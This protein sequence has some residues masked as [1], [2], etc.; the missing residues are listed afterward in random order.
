MKILVADDDRVSQRLLQVLLKKW[1]HETLLA[2]DGIETLKIMESSD[3]P[4]IVL[5][6][7][8]MPGMD[9]IEVCRRIRSQNTASPPYIIFI[10]AKDGSVDMVRG[11]ESG[12]SDFIRKPFKKEELKARIGV[13]IRTVNL[14]EELVK[15]HRMMEQIAMYD[16][17][18]ETF[19]RRAMMD[20]IPREISRVKRENRLLSL[21]LLDIDH[22][23]KINDT[24]GHD[25]GDAALV[26]FAC[27]TRES[28]RRYDTVCRWGGEEFLVLAPYQ[29]ESADESV[30]NPVFE[31]IRTAAE[32]LVVHVEGQ[33]IRF[34]VSIGVAITSGDDSPAALVKRADEALYTAKNTGRNRVI[35]ADGPGSESTTQAVSPTPTA[36]QAEPIS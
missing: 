8:E 24:H 30:V 1:G 26:E 27:A 20:I 32:K 34:T 29:D 9:G 5:L 7:W 36:D 19:N 3:S 11:L 22:F 16:P 28:I 6:D 25:A 2:G 14:Q 13:G 18:T 17:L 31:R 4:M 35:Y 23:K 15:A 33:A 10:T 21:G 12:A